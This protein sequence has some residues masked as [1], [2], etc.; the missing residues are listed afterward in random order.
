MHLR[1]RNVNEAFTKLVGAVHSG[2]IPTR[3]SPS[4]Y[5]DVRVIDEPVTITY[6]RP[7]ERVLFNAA[8]DCNPFFHLTES[9]WMLAGREDVAPLAYY[10]SRMPEFSDDGKVFNGAYGN[11]W[12]NWRVPAEDKPFPMGTDGEPW[13]SVRWA[14][15]DQLDVIVD[16]L[17]ADPTSRRMVL[18]MW[19]VH[20]DLLRAV[21]P[22]K[23]RDV[24]CNL[25]AM[26]L[27][28]PELCPR[29]GGPGCHACEDPRAEVDVDGNC[30]QYPGADRK[31]LDITVCNRSND[32][33]WGMLGAN[34]VQF[35]FLQEYL[36][37]RLGV[38]VGRY[39]QVTNNLH[40]YDKTWHP[41]RWLGPEPSGLDEL[42]LRYPGTSPLMKD[43][44]AFDWGLGLFVSMFS[45]TCPVDDLERTVWKCPWL[46]NVAKPMLLAFAH[47]KAARAG[48][49]SWDATFDTVSDC[50]A[51]DWRK[52][53]YEWLLRRRDNVGAKAGTVQA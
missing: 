5:G 44:E 17:R 26:F 8:R 10:N 43:P 4:R 50:A 12:R 13:R 16:E 3:R 41:D 52:A 30:A 9:L 31:V 46:E 22:N 51:P 39:H 7:R 15:V 47:Y 34:V 29:C 40:V 37:G 32:L 45:G 2:S 49:G 38:E 14:A 20:S 23:S 6:E 21:G 28:R 36:A 48:G 27:V 25:N 53:G 42:G 35:S 19:S 24:C 11:R 18:E 1:Y 33:V